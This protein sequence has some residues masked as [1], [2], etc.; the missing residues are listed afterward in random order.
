MDRFSDLDALLD[1]ALQRVKDP[2]RVWLQ[3]SLGFD[4]R[5]EWGRGMILGGA[6]SP[7]YLT[8]RPADDLRRA[9]PYTVWL[10]HPRFLVCPAPRPDFKD[11]IPMLEALAKL[12]DT[13][14]VVTPRMESD[15][16]F[17]T[18]LA[19]HVRSVIRCVVISP[20][21][22][23]APDLKALSRTLDTLELRPSPKAPPSSY[24]AAGEIPLPPLLDQLPRA[25]R[26]A[27]RRGCTVAIPGPGA[28][29]SPALSEIAIV[30]VGGEHADDL[31]DR[32]VILDDLLRQ[33][34]LKDASPRS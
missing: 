3:S 29:Q 26:V 15:D 22:A 34:E 8:K 20:G 30:H 1:E 4:S 14:I 11:W 16:L 33:R 18:L 32:L 31:Q 10:E 19:N 6:L 12:S 24:L 17:A 2:R 13:L 25:E 23:Q 5:I 28:E 7:H 9:V 27:I 21:P